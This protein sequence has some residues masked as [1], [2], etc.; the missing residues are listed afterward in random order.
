VK[1]TCKLLRFVQANR[2]TSLGPGRERAPARRRAFRRDATRRRCAAA[3]RRRTT[4][5]TRSLGVSTV[6]VSTALTSRTRLGRRAR[7]PHDVHALAA[8]PSILPPRRG[9]LYRALTRWSLRHEV[10]MPRHAHVGY[11][12]PPLWL[13][14]EHTA[15]N[16]PPLP[17]PP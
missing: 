12:S 10:N 5:G 16:R 4:A 11:K 13:P 8:A 3:V 7:A 6:C 2:G 15:V 9:L 1:F 14:P 17:P